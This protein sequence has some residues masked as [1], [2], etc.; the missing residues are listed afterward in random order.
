VS[1]N[2]LGGDGCGPA[3][4]NCRSLRCPN[5]CVV[6][7]NEALN[8][9]ARFAVRGQFPFPVGMSVYSA[10]YR[11]RAAA[12]HKR[13][14]DHARPET[15]LLVFLQ[16]ID[17]GRHMSYRAVASTA[18][19]LLLGRHRLYGIFSGERSYVLGGLPSHAGRLDQR[20]NC[21]PQKLRCTAV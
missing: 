6:R 10:T 17:V 4:T 2:C 13:Y 20:A 3:Q 18:A 12:S 1:P 21:G 11:K 19:P 7:S 5:V 8:V 16:R 14:G 15:A 9:S